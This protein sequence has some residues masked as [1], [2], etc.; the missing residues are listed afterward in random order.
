MA[1]SLSRLAECTRSG[2]VRPNLGVGQLLIPL[3][4]SPAI[5]IPHLQDAT[6]LRNYSL[7]SRRLSK[8]AFAARAMTQACFAI[9]T[10]ALATAPK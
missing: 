1:S 5:V 3:L 4:L 6:V 2:N 10:Q 8:K 9:L 7:Q